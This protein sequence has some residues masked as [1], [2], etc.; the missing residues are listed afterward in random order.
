MSCILNVQTERAEDLILPWV[1]IF[2]CARKNVLNAPGKFLS[3][4]PIFSLLLGAKE[5][6]QGAKK[7]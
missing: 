3:F 1:L 4:S 7:I 6:T 2:I 5:F